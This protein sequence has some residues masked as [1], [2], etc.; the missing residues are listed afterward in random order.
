VVVSFLAHPSHAAAC[1]W[2]CRARSAVCHPPHTSGRIE[3][4]TR[5]LRFPSSHGTNLLA[6]SPVTSYLFKAHH[7]HPSGCLSPLHCLS[8]PIKGCNASAITPAAFCSIQLCLSMP[9]ATQHRAPLPPFPPL[10]CRPHLTV[11]P[12]VATFGED[13]I[14]L[15]PLFLHPR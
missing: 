9:Q 15:L 14:D 8:N 12:L 11:E 6:S 13:P 10:R 1:G 3:P 4:V 5:D 2:H 7:C